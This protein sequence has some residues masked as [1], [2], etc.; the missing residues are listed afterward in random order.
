M[1]GWWATRSQ[2]AVFS[3]RRELAPTGDNRFKPKGA[4][5]AEGTV[6]QLPKGITPE[7]SKWNLSASA[8]QDASRPKPSM[9]HDPLDALPSQLTAPVRGGEAGAFQM[10]NVMRAEEVI[11]AYRISEG[12]VCMLKARRQAATPESLAGTDWAASTI[13]APIVSSSAVTITK[14]PSLGYRTAQAAIP[15][16][17]SPSHP[18]SS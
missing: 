5:R 12:R 4:W 15:A 1:A 8:S 11:A 17:E 16:A 9:T 18:T 2:L 6:H 3:F 10:W 7:S 13:D 14:S